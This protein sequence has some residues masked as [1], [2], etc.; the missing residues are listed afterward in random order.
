MRLTVI[1][2]KT[3]NNSLNTVRDINKIL[4]FFNHVIIFST[5]WSLNVLFLS[6]IA[7]LQ[8]TSSLK[9]FLKSLNHALE[10]I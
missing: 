2:E 5:D 1:F 3:G 6:I 7:T 8:S 10:S 9:N 4:I